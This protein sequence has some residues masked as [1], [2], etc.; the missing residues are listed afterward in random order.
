MNK[1]NLYL[2]GSDGF[3]GKSI[4]KN[5]E[6]QKNFQIKY[7]NRKKCNFLNISN[8]KS[9]SK[10]INNNSV[11]VM[12]IGIKKQLGDNYDNYILNMKIFFNFLKLI[13]SKKKMSIVFFSSLEV[14]SNSNTKLTINEQTPYQ[15]ST[16]YGLA[17]IQN[18][19]I[20]KKFC[21]DKNFRYIIIRP[22]LIYGINDK[23][24]GYG[25]TNFFYQ[26]K[27]NKVINIW[28]NG[29]ELREFIYVEDIPIIINKLLK[30]KK[31]LE[32]NIISGKSYNYNDIIKSLKI[33]SKK[34]INFK[35]KKRTGLITNHK[36]SKINLIKLIGNFKFTHLTDGL[37]S[38]HK[39]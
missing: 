22:P 28:G 2:L 3:L 29:K 19:I 5:I 36:Y 12:T 39:L 20:L 18:E 34:N 21:K 30:I 13:E 14:F 16:Y 1:K 35:R 10:L 23:S 26:F 8:L 17:K 37:R 31:S 15:T 4:K 27:S 33:I 25:P 38:M 32:I 6:L 9:N 24:K 11:I 7:F